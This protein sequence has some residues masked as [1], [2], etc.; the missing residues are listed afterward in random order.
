TSHRQTGG[1]VPS[2]RFLIG[3]MIA[4]VPKDYAG[5][6]VE[7]GAGTGALTLKLAARCP[8]ARILALEIN[9]RLAADA[10]QN[11]AAAGLDGRVEVMA[12]SAEGLAGLLAARGLGPLDYVI[13]GVPLANLGSQRA[14]ALIDAV[15][16]SLGSGGSYVQFQHS[17]THQ[18]RIGARF[19]SLRTMPVL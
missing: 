18:A 9:G 14:L 1:F 6:I 13:S 15:R 10:R 4:P 7:L 12:G 17:T 19:A 5:T 11:V 16:D 3:R 2:Q 8:R